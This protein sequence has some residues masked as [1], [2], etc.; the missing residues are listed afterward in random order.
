[1]RTPV[2]TEKKHIRLALGK[3]CLR[4][5]DLINISCT[6]TKLSKVILPTS[7]ARSINCT[8]LDLYPVPPPVYQ[9]RSIRHYICARVIMEIEMHCFNIKKL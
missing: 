7:T 5:A 9:Y 6:I 4:G 2:A 3:L 8:A 1:M